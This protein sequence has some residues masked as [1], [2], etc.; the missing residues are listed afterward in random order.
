MIYG[1]G[2]IEGMCTQAF[3]LE[4]KRVPNLFTGNSF[5]IQYFPPL[6]LWSLMDPF[7]VPSEISVFQG[8]AGV[9][10]FEGVE[11]SSFFGGK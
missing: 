6:S 5:V 4:Q 7:I 3:R 8:W 2:R 11:D 9:S 1:N 10:L